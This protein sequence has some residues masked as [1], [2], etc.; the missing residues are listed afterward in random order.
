MKGAAGVKQGLGP[1]L[2]MLESQDSRP[3]QIQMGLD[4]A[5]SAREKFPKDGL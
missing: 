4:L 3:C 5:H 2:E 1:G